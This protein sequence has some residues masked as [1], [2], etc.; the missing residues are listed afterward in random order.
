[1]QGRAANGSTQRLPRLVESRL[2][3]LLS[4]RNV[5][6][7]IIGNSAALDSVLEHEVVVLGV[8]SQ[9]SSFSSV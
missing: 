4:C 8:A 5:A 9:M 1:M 2:H 3:A 6:A 7:E